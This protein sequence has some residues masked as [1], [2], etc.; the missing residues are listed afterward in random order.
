KILEFNRVQVLLAL[1]VQVNYVGSRALVVDPRVMAEPLD[2]LEI[3]LSLLAKKLAFEAV[4][5]LCSAASPAVLNPR[6]IQRDAVAC[7][8][9]DLEVWVDLPCQV[10]KLRQQRPIPEHLLADGEAFFAQ[11]PALAIDF[12]RHDIFGLEQSSGHRIFE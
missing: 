9:F 4:M 10:Q 5:A 8:P 6:G 1:E 3:E 11:V 7:V 12:P 2:L